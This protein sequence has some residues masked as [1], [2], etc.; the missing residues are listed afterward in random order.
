MHDADRQRMQA[1]DGRNTM[2]DRCSA[3][4][5][6]TRYDGT[7]YSRDVTAREAD[8]FPFIFVTCRDLA[9]SSIGSVLQGVPA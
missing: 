8:L 4:G 6:E 5:S 1:P 2:I 9:V 7:R 3:H